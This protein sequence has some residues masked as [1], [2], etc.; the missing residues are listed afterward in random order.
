MHSEEGRRHGIPE[1]HLFGVA[2]WAET[3]FFSEKERAALALTDAATR[4]LDGVPDAVWEQAVAH[5]G[6]A[7]AAKLVFVIAAINVWNR[8]AI[9]SRTTPRSAAG[10]KPG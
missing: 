1:A 6:D 5:W 4:L 7:G 9:S 10:K 3:P 2:A 8:I